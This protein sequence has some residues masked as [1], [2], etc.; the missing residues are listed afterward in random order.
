MLDD[1]LQYTSAQTRVESS[2]INQYA[3]RQA[4]ISEHQ[5]AIRRYLNLK[6]FVDA[7]IELVKQYV[8]GQSCRLEQTGALWSLVEQYLKDHGILQP[9][10]STLQRMIGEQRSLARQSI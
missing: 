4:T 1:L 3:S 10:D 2:E 8:F 7:N 6:E 5:N 9:A